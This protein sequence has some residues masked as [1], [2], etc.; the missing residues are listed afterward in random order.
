M[1]STF[2]CQIILTLICQTL[3][4]EPTETDLECFNDYETEMKCSFWFDGLKSCSGYKLNITQT[5]VNTLKKYTCM[6]EKSHYRAN[7]ECKIKVQ[8]FVVSEIFS[9]TLLNGTDVLLSKTFVTEDFI[10]PK[11]PVLSVQKTENGDYNVTWDD[12][13]EKSYFA[14]GLEIHLTYK[15]EGGNETMSRNVSNSLGFD[16]IVGRSLQPNTNYI[17]TARMSTGYNEHKILSDQSA[18]VEFTSSSSP[19]EL[20]R[21]MVPPLCV[22][23]II[24]IGSIFMCVLRMKMNLWDNISKPKIDAYLGEEKGRILPASFMNLS[25]IQVEI[26]KLDFQEEKKLISTSSVDTNNEKSS[27]SVESAAGDY[28]QAGFDSGNGKEKCSSVNVQLR[29][30]HA[31]REDLKFLNLP[32]IPSNQQVKS[33]DDKR[34]DGRPETMV[35]QKAQPFKRRHGQLPRHTSFQKRVVRSANDDPSV[36]DQLICNQSYQ[37]DKRDIFSCKQSFM[38]ADTNNE[39][40]SRSVES[41]AGDYGQAGFDSGNGK[42]KCSSVNVPLRIEHALREDLNFLNLPNIPSN[43]Q[44]KSAD[45]KRND[46]RPETMVLLKTQPFKPRYGLRLT[47]FQKRVVRSANDDPSVQDQLICNQSYQSDIFSCK[48]SLMSA[49]ISKSQLYVLTN[50]AFEDEYQS[51]NCEIVNPDFCMNRSNDVDSDEKFIV[52]NLITSNPPVCP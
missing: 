30:E 40:S 33:A 51:F 18:P 34:N 21:T 1:F 42:E 23:L 3:C 8:E 31:L 52:K 48:Q 36:Q 12:K 6:F 32:N 4:Y 20:L 41:A 9:T 26:P 16:E 14:R 10:K 17:L 2:L 27:R 44:V 22:V 15:I 7:C 45:D 24:I 5:V 29:I 49:D 13:Y 46:G 19:N 11:T 28:G 25:S 38:S 35:L 37:S 39:K 50:D 43:Q 47:S